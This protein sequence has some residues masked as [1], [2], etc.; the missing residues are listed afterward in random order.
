ME[1]RQRKGTGSRASQHPRLL[2]LLLAGFIEGAHSGRSRTI[3]I[4]AAPDAIGGLR[5][6]A[7]VG[8]KTFRILCS[9]PAP[10]S[11]RPTRLSAAPLLRVLEDTQS[12]YSI[13][14]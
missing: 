11:C 10:R 5:I 4:S 2:T 8:T 7:C 12:G 3:T 13:H 1:Q 14:C 9:G 6:E